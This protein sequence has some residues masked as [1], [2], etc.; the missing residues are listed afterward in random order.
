VR[1]SQGVVIAL[2]LGVRRSPNEPGGAPRRTRKRTRAA[3]IYAR[4]REAYPER[5]CALDHRR[6]LELLVATILSA[7]CTDKR[8]NEVTPALFR[9]YQSAAAYARA[10]LPELEEMVRPTGFFRNKARAL[11]GLG[12]ALVA[13]HDGTVP[14]EMEALR[15]PASA[16]D[17]QRGAR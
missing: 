1:R 16:A 11:K 3:E 12:Q 6:P 9:R 2:Q 17:R 13:E 10:P 5:H 7:Q 8:V 15:P 14:D 4:L